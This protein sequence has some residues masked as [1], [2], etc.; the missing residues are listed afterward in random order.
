MTPHAREEQAIRTLAEQLVGRF[1]DG[2]LRK[3]YSTAEIQQDCLALIRTFVATVR[4]QE[5]AREQAQWARI[6]DVCNGEPLKEDD[7]DTVKTIYHAI[8]S[9][10]T[11]FYDLQDELVEATEKERE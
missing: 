8:K 1:N 3:D 5:R 7:G 10:K 11:K 9:W 2:L 6:V 4:A